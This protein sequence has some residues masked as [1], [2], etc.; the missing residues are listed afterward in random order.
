MKRLSAL[1]IM[2]AFVALVVGLMSP[3]A[4]PQS[5]SFQASRNFAAGFGPRSVAVGDFNGD[6]KP[7]LVVAN[8]GDGNVS[9]LLGNGDG[10]FQAA[11]NYAVGDN[12]ISV[13]V[14]DFNGD[15]KPD[16]VVAINGGNAVAST[17]SVL[18]GK[19]DGTFQAAK[20]YAVGE[21]PSSV[22]VGDF[23]G[24]GKPDFVVV[25]SGDLYGYMSVFLSKGD[26][27]F[28]AAANYLWGSTFSSPSSV[29]V[30]DFNGDGRPDFVVVGGGTY[31][32]GV[33]L[34]NGDGSFQPMWAHNSAV[35]SAI[36]VAVGAFNGDGKPDLA[37]VT[38]YNPVDPEVTVSI[39]L[40][41]GDGT[42]QAPVNYAAG[43]GPYSVAVGDFDGDGKPDL[44]V[45]D[46][47]GGVSVLLNNGDGTFQAAVNYG[48]GSEP[49]CVAVGDFNGDGKPDLAVANYNNGSAGT[50][51][52]LPG[53]GDGTF[54][55]AVT[56]AA[57]GWARS[58][59]VGD[60]NGDGK[61]DLAVAHDYGVSVL[62]G[63]G[64]GTFQA[65]ANYAWGSIPYSVAVGDF[66]GDGKADL[67]VANF[68]DTVSVLLGNGD[69]TFQ[70]AVNYSAGS[71]PYSVAVGD[72]N[73]DGK[74]DLA[75]ANN[76]NGSAGT[77]SVLLGN[78]DGT[79]QAAVNYSAGSGPYSVAVGDFNGDGKPDLAVANNG[80]G[81]NSNV[82]VLLGNGD[83]S[84]QAAVT[85]PAGNALISVAVGDFNGDGNTDLVVANGTSNPGTVSVLLGNGD[86]SFQPAVKYAASNGPRSV[87][88]GDFNGDGRA[89]LAVAD[90]D[91]SVSV[92]PGNGDGTFQAPVNYAAGNFPYSVAVGDFNG[93]GKPDL[94]VAN[95]ANPGGVTIILNL[96]TWT[97][98]NVVGAT[99][100]A[101]TTAITG[102]SL[103]LGTVTN[104]TS[105]TVPIGNVISESPAAGTPVNGGTA[106][107]LVISSGVAVPNVV[108][109]TQT[110]AATAITSAGLVVGTVT[111][112]TSSTVP[113]GSVISESPVAGTPVNGGTAVNL[114]LS[115]GVA[116][117]NV[118]GATQA[119]AT[120]AITGAGL[121]LGTVTTASSTVP[122]GN[123]ISESPA[124][125][126][127]VNGGTAVDL[128]L[129]SGVAVPNVVGATQA[130]ATT[131][132]TGASLVLGTVTNA[133]SGTV[134][135]GNVISESPAAGTPVNGGTA[136]N[137]VISSGVTVPNVVGATQTAATTAITGAGLAL[138][139]VTTASSST[140]PYGNVISESPA[141]GTPVNGGTAV[142]LVVSSGRAATST[143]VITSLTPALYGQMIT[144]TATVTNA[145]S[146]GTPT[147]TVTF[148][149][150]TV[151]FGT[152]S[153]NASGQ[154]AYST[155][156]LPGGVGVQSITAVYSGDPNFSTS[157][158]GAILQTIL[159]APVVSL[160]PDAITFHSE[161]VNTTSA[162][163]PVVLTNQG[164][165]TLTISG[166]QITGG[167]NGDFFIVSNTCG[168]SLAALSSCTVSV[169]F[170][171]RDTG[172]RTSSLSF[173]DN[174]DGIA[175]SNQLVSLT[176]SALSVV[177][178]N[179]SRPP[180][181]AG[182]TI[183]FDSV[184]SAK[185]PR[186][187][188]GVQEMDLS[189][190][191]VN[192]YVTN[193]TITFTANNTTYNLPVPDAMITFTPTVTSAT[194]TFDSVNNRW[195]TTVPSAE[196]A[197]HMQQFDIAGEVFASGL[198]FPVPAGG[199]PGGITNVSWSAAFMTDTPGVTLSW[200]WGAAVY[201]TFTTD[202]NLLG[203]GVKSGDDGKGHCHWD[204]NG[205]RAGTP[206]NF[207]QY[208]VMGA[209]ADGPRDYTGDFTR[210]VGV[211]PAAIVVSITPI[212]VVFAAPQAANTT[213]SPMT[214][215]ITNIHQS[216]NVAVAS[217][218]VNGDFAVTALS[219]SCPT[220]TTGF[221]LA[222]GNSCAFNVTFGPTDLGT[223][224]GQL[225]FTLG[226][227]AGMSANDVPPPQKVDLV[228]TG[229][230]GTAPIAALSQ[231]G[232]NFG[233]EENGTT[234]APQTVMLVN[235]GGAQL[236]ITSIG[237]VPSGDFVITSNTCGGSLAPAANCIVAVSFTPTTTG[238]R[239]GQLTFTYDNNNL[240]GL[241]QTVNLTGK[242]TP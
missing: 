170:S 111:T 70:A 127:P 5:V 213:S 222:P 44:A 142:N 75:V 114:V 201:S 97:V 220:G 13:A 166:I 105:G 217:V 66:N 162:P 118:V 176:G 65:A 141:A 8:N 101:A 198:S 123:V 108:G 134:P 195:V 137:L 221:T 11:V 230:G 68:Y 94:A 153:L 156:V 59:A 62:L 121:V 191:T 130:A 92:L 165:A 145:S 157:T 7:D 225:I 242:G 231:L 204:G 103:V 135:I 73:G 205:D 84:F 51:S 55:A 202:Y 107:D 214:V 18:L 120:T 77:A 136:V 79:F 89:D 4:T 6:G 152:S 30:G 52:V 159:A 234:S 178:A 102:A 211:V 126:T 54:R 124:A 24:D 197:K 138:G 150:G 196:P 98:P 26:G 209:T 96:T 215:T 87:A 168:S 181:A 95:D 172:T 17:V 155:F 80:G 229:A 16:L 69:G 40:G 15:G 233:R 189:N 3:V 238:Q 147:G 14:G 143:V 184:L 171:P 90:V 218:A 232:L 61:P 42:F 219:G 169:V 122:I 34:N 119:E 154:T 36:S 239:T 106:V 161:D 175:N 160:D 240:S 38:S 85:H 71:G 20:N 174:N 41:N 1:T 164:N 148:Y 236:N 227:I 131:A 50:V 39:L 177:S 100:T 200:E 133:T 203:I 32:M 180:I 224:T 139:T 109:I 45:A 46:A 57:G 9:V 113:I 22:A 194:T 27:T 186:G 86:G 185:P 53:K 99:Q 132:I 10:A 163:M 25:G 63:N 12:P 235:A 72:F 206:E 74:P 188:D 128:V 28:Q 88:V 110:A 182:S 210:D 83:G 23:N 192:V 216:M 56:Y 183:W 151:A 49:F 237:I 140:V 48:A 193:G 58:V 81:S 167:N 125:G 93:D 226:A 187:P 82:S 144:F 116:V 21:G 146:S 149:D 64:D 33:F 31:S 158:S 67:A 207:K 37:T 115:S 76:N 78:G 29:A 223:R 199:L 91:G 43:S 60:F 212:P 117:P 112:A 228:G 2:V 104:A 47:G 173:T 35:V 241:S 190:H 179:F 129:S 208:L 19:G